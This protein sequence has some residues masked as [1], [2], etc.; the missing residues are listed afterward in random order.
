[1]PPQFL[2]NTVILCLEKRFSK[3]NSVIRRKS[4][5]L[6]PKIFSP[7][8]NFWSGYATV[9]PHCACNHTRVLLC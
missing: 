9:N 6:D 7:P 4:N 8:P 2:K 3:Q 5:I 1:M